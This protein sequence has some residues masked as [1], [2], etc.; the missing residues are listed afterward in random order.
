MGDVN[1]RAFGS[2]TCDS[3]DVYKSTNNSDKYNF[4]EIIVFENY[5]LENGVLGLKRDTYLGI[6]KFLDPSI[7]RKVF[8]F[9]IF[10]VFFVV[11]WH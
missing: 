2:K 11:H 3:V 1:S 8:F 7:L 6:V 10:Y 9:L 4:E 5:E